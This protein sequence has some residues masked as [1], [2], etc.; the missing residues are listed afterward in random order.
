VEGCKRRM[1]GKYKALVCAKDGQRGETR[2]RW[3]AVMAKGSGGCIRQ[4]VVDALRGAR[5]P[6]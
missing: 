6:I 3:W 5:R 4:P 1:Y 2:E